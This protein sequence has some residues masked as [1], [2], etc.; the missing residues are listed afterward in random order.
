MNYFRFRFFSTLQTFVT[1]TVPILALDPVP[2]HALD[3]PLS[4]INPVS[5]F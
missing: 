1:N 4:S 3:P 5:Q 2:D